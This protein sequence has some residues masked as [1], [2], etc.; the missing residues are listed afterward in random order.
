LAALRQHVSNHPD[1][2]A[3]SH[4]QLQLLYAA[5][6]AWRFKLFCD[7]VKQFLFSCFILRYKTHQM[8]S[9]KDADSTLCRAALRCAAM[10][11]TMQCVTAQHNTVHWHVLLH[12]QA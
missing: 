3:V 4:W 2:L 11:C 8:A 7:P 6:P 9:A 1:V 5:G 10:A 12:P